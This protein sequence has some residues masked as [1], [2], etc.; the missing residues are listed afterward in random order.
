MSAIQPDT[1]LSQVFIV[2]CYSKSCHFFYGYVLLQRKLKNQTETIH[3]SYTSPRSGRVQGDWCSYNLSDFFLKPALHYKQ[4]M[5]VQGRP[6]SNYSAVHRVIKSQMTSQLLISGKPCW[7]E[8]TKTCGGGKQV[9]CLNNTAV[10]RACNTIRCPG[11]RLVTLLCW[12]RLEVDI[13]NWRNQ[14]LSG[15]N[16]LR[17]YRGCL[18]PTLVYVMSLPSLSFFFASFSGDPEWTKCTLTC[19]GGMQT[20]IDNSSI[21]RTCNTMAC[22]GIGFLLVVFLPCSIFY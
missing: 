14:E 13:T 3:L 20:K 17:F 12:S 9:T 11:K 4:V 16:E 15:E 7:T 5:K 19:G 6:T 18:G 2:K 8:C 10:T 22:P 1:V 21:I